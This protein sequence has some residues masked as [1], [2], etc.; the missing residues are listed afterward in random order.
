VT[1]QRRT[2]KD[3]KKNIGEQKEEIVPSNNKK[4]NEFGI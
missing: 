1:E 3:N 4:I 2:R